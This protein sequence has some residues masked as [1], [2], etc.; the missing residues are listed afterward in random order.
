MKQR[1][2]SL[3]TLWPIFPQCIASLLMLSMCLFAVQQA[4]AQ[5]E[6]VATASPNIQPLNIGD[7]IP[8]EVWD[9]PLQ[10]VNH[11][12]GKETITLA[13][14][15]DKLIIIDFWATFCGS[16]ISAMPK[17]HEVQRQFADEMVVIPVSWSKPEAT[18]QT[19]R[20]H[21]TLWP[22]GLS[23]VVEAKA[24]IGLFPH[25]VVPHYVWIDPQG[26]VVATTAT[27]DVSV[28]NIAKVL[29]GEEPDYALKTHIDT[30]KPLLFASEVLPKGAEIQ[31]YSVF[32]KGDMPSLNSS[33]KLRYNQDGTV[34]G[35]AILN[36][37]LLSIYTT[38][39]WQIFGENPAMRINLIDG[40]TDS[41]V[42]TFDFIIPKVHSDSIFQYLLINLNQIS[43]YSAQLVKRKRQCLILTKTCEGNRFISTAQEKIHDRDSLTYHIQQHPITTLTAFLNGKSVSASLLVLNETGY[44][45]MVDIVL[46]APF[47]DL[48]NIRKQLNRHG[49]DL[50]VADREIKL[51]EIRK[52]QHNRLFTKK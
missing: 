36:R 33:V 4:S 17:I 46:N 22:L 20:N 50:T 41:S 18:E 32:I 16:C 1:L 43:G 30:D 2:R 24:L 27:N 51:L 42:Y 45:G 26:R 3:A 35:I 9:M 29:E 52:S 8:D 11:P 44:D 49:L 15:K 37:P 10:V 6:P 5:A 12:E 19:L 7:P 31:H 39:A 47:N 13:D 14:Y 23:S 34:N 38:I 48:D 40:I 25:Q 28:D 21:Q